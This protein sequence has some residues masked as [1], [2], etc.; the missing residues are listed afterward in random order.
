[1]WYNAALKS[2]LHALLT[3]AV[4]CKCDLCIQVPLVMNEIDWKKKKLFGC[5]CAYK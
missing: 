3:K 4:S 1:M 5:P 2:P